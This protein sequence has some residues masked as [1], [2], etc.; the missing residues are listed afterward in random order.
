MYRLNRLQRNVLIMTDEVI[1]H[2]PTK[3]TLDPRMVENSIIVAEERFISTAL[4]LKLYNAIC[5][6]KNRLVTEGNKVA[7]QAD[8][9]ASLPVGSQPVVLTA[10]DIINAAEYLSTENLALWKQ[11]LWKLTA[12]A[13]MLLALPEGFVQFGSEGAIHANPPAGPMNSS[14]LVTPDL[15]S[16]K[17]MM[18]K[19][20][21]DRI[22]PLAQGMHTWICNQKSET[23]TLYPLYKKECECDN[24]GQYAR[25]TDVI[26]GIYDDQDDDNRY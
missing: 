1:F 12:E 15:K 11:Y 5:A 18:D 24:Q 23:S 20:I 13:V 16:M 8:I 25:K 21:Q 26:L 4:G 10:G 17:W 3:H 9:N 7:L 14:G 6:Q 19:K 22:D 2:A